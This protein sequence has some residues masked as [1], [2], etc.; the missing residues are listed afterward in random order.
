M[1]LLALVHFAS[2]GLG[3]L[4]SEEQFLEAAGAI[5][6]GRVGYLDPV[7]ARC[8]EK[9][10]LDET[11]TTECYAVAAGNPRLAVPGGPAVYSPAA[12]LLSALYFAEGNLR[13]A[14]ALGKDVDYALVT[15]A[16]HPQ[17]RVVY[18]GLEKLADTQA[19]PGSVAITTA[20]VD[21]T[22]HGWRV[23]TSVKYKSPASFLFGGGDVEV[24]ADYS[25]SIDRSLET[26][27]GLSFE[28]PAGATCTPHLVQYSL[29]CDRVQASFVFGRNA[30]V[31]ATRTRPKSAAPL[32]LPLLKTKTPSFFE[33]VAGCI[34]YTA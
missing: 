34:D 28:I 21:K 10:T 8:N 20:Q 4:L 31:L 15:M 12:S 7:K 9:L 3:K 13:D 19:G 24:S 16:A 33:T 25:G 32:L 5:L 6:H 17:C 23:G 26:A 1:K 18:Y 27:V 29:L 11:G 14:E 2:V 22:A 30:S